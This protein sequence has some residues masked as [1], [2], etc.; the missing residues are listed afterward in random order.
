MLRDIRGLNT[1]H[2]VLPSSQKD[3]N[4]IQ[5]MKSSGNVYQ[6]FLVAVVDDEETP[7]ATQGVLTSA[8]T[9]K[10]FHKGV[11]ELVEN[12]DIV[13]VEPPDVVKHSLVLSPLG[14]MKCKA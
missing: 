6:C 4:S 2:K 5:I 10:E 9:G 13:P 3:H 1:S 12:R 11:E 7:L 14:V 8:G